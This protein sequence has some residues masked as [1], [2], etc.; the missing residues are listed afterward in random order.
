[1]SSVTDAIRA[2]CTVGQ[3]ACL[4]EALCAYCH[5]I[6]IEKIEQAFSAYIFIK[7]FLQFRSFI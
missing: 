1:M 6:S 2:T 3:P 5:H 4:C 7:H